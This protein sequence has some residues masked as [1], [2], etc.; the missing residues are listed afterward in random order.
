MN[1]LILTGRLVR[2]INLRTSDSGTVY[3]RFDLA[4]KNHRAKDGVEYH[5]FTV[6]GAEAARMA[7]Y[8]RKGQWLSIQGRVSNR[9]VTLEGGASIHVPQLIATHVEYGPRPKRST[10]ATE[11]E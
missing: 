8:T 9:K 4:E 1:Q 6:F 10:Q 5:E 2:S 11:E 3:A 7:E